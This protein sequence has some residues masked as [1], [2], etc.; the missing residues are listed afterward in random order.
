VRREV[1]MRM[2]ASWSLAL[3]AGPLIAASSN[4]GFVSLSGGLHYPSGEIRELTDSTY[5]FH[6]N[7]GLGTYATAMIGFP[8]FELDWGHVSGKGNTLDT[9]A[10]TYVERVNLQEGVYVGGGLGTAMNRWVLSSQSG[11]DDSAEVNFRPCVR[12]LVGMTLARQ[13]FIEG[14][15]FYNGSIGGVDANAISLVAGI[16]F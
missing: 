14:N 2:L 5:G 13:F 8:T 15:A 6:V 9:V 1:A 4:D 10:F 3:L 11:G 12:G 7:G 16:R